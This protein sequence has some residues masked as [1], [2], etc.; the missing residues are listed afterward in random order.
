MIGLPDKR[1]NL[2]LK[3]AQAKTIEKVEKVLSDLQKIK[4]E[5]NSSSTSIARAITSK[6]K[7]VVQTKDSNSD[8]SSSSPT[9]IQKSK[10][11]GKLILDMPEVKR[12]VGKPNPMTF[13]KNWYSKPTLLGMQ[14][15]E[16]LH[17]I[18]QT[19][20]SIFANRFYE[21]NID[22]LSKQ[23]VLNKMNH[24]S[25]VANAYVTNHN[26]DHGEIVDILTIGFSGTLR[27]W[28]DKYLIEDSRESIKNSVK[29][30]DDGMPIF[31]ER[32]GRGIL[33]GVNTLIYTI[34][35]HL[36][37]TPSNIT[38]RISDYLNNL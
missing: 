6:G 2:N 14:F 15:E 19:Q 7:E 18:S 17:V 3:T 20:F 36:I 11:I 31:D 28:W 8:S 34:I 9:D 29:K 35:K 16:P 22:G 12:F 10:S 27:H 25:M 26:L 37:G 32:I 23:E 38:S 33:D 30:D 4:T 13:T 1:H 24:M 21:W 5:H